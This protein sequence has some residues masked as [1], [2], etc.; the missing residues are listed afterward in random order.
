MT[1]KLLQEFAAQVFGLQQFAL[2]HQ[3]HHRNQ[4]LRQGLQPV[5]LRLD[6][7]RLGLSA[8]VYEERELPAPARFERRIETA[9]QG[10]G[11]QR[12]FRMAEIT[13]VMAFFL[14]GTAMFRQRVLETR[15]VIECCLVVTQVTSAN[16]A[17]IERFG[18]LRL[19]S[20]QR[21]ELATIFCR[22]RASR[23][24]VKN[25]SSVVRRSCAAA[26]R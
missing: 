24:A 22:T 14:V 3:I 21:L 12:L 9:G 25:S 26:H 4:R 16:R 2:M 17:H 7:P 23:S 8:G 13:E 19:G 15:Y 18:I 20:E 10:I 5:E 1:R 11:P 6:L